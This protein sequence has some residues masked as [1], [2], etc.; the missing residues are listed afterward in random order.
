MSAVTFPNWY[1]P[2]VN[3][4][5][6]NFVFYVSIGGAP[7][8]KFSFDLNMGWYTTAA[9][10]MNAIVVEMNAAS[11]VVFNAIVHTSVYYPD[12]WILSVAAGNTFYI[13][14]TC[15]FVV[16]GKLL[17]RIPSSTTLAATVE[18]GPIGLKYTSYVD[19]TS[20]ALTRSSRMK[21]V[22]TSAKGSILARVPVP[23][24]EVHNIEFRPQFDIT[25]DIRPDQQLTDIDIQLFDMYGYPLYIPPQGLDVMQVLLEIKKEA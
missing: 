16:Y 4:R 7:A 17:A 24:I 14:P 5:N 23:D 21:P 22:A 20:V 1:I 18:F 6:R 25:Y 15:D 9:I 12:I 3:D 11:G 13:D 2:N 19:V 8:V 10:L